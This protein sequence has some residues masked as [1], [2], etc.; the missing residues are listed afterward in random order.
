[1]AYYI[2]QGGACPGRVC[3][4]LQHLL[5]ARAGAERLHPLRTVHCSYRERAS[6]SRHPPRKMRH[7]YAVGTLKGGVSGNAR[8]LAR[9]PFRKGWNTESGNRQ[10]PSAAAVLQL[11]SRCIAHTPLPVRYAVDPWIATATQGYTASFEG[12]GYQRVGDGM[13]SQHSRT[14]SNNRYMT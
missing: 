1:M 3:V 14:C 11:K 5:D 10:R 2:S 12:V 7:T 13:V 4:V 6:V 9:A 8:S